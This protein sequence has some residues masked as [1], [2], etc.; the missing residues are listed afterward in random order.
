M[1]VLMLTNTRSLR[2]TQFEKVYENDNNASSFRFLIP[3][4]MDG[5]NMKMFDIMLKYTA[6]DNQ[7]EYLNV[8]YEE[9]Q[10]EGMLSIVVP[11]TR[12]FTY[13]QGR[14]KLSLVFLSKDSTD[15]E[16]PTPMVS[17]IVFSSAEAYIDIERNNNY[18]SVSRVDRFIQKVND[19]E[20]RTVDNI[21]V[22]PETMEMQL[23]SNDKP[24]GDKVKIPC[25]GGNSEGGIDNEWSEIGKYNTET[26][27]AEWDKI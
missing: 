17:D 6:P 7:L 16:F 5:L 2:T 25:N 27:D 12:K 13:K 8:Q 11:I 23:E 9:F 4:T 20:Q 3:P 10:Y 24:I 26:N 15:G 21:K 19:I 22:Y 14:L 18:S 1:Y